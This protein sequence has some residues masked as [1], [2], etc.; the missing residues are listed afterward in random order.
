MALATR[1]CGAGCQRIGLCG[2]VEVL[3]GFFPGLL[4]LA[5]ILVMRH[6]NDLLVC[7][8]LVGTAVV[9]VV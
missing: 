2:K 6:S 5:D 3:V 7:A 9:R 4:F 1:T 8:F